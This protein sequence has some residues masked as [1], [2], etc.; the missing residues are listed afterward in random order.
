MKTVNLISF[1]F[2]LTSFHGAM[3]AT[4]NG[5][6]KNQGETLNFELSGQKNWDYDLK[7][8]KEKNQTKVQLL[9]N[10][11]TEDS[12]SKIKNVDNPYVESIIVQ[13]HVAD[14]KWLIEFVLKNDNVDT[15]DYLT[16][17]PSKL[18]VDFYVNENAQDDLIA[19]PDA[20]VKKAKLDTKAA[21]KL[22]A[23]KLPSKKS[24]SEFD[25][26]PEMAERK[27]AQAD[28]LTVDQAGGIETSSLLKGRLNDGADAFLERF[29]IKDIEINEK[30][31]LKSDNNYYLRFPMLE[32]PFSFWDKMKANPPVYQFEPAKTEEN[33]QVRLIKTLFDKK[34]FQVFAKTAEWFE[35]KY[36]KS[37]YLESIA[38]M[39]S[40]A[41]LEQWKQ[42][43][44]DKAFDEAKQSY[45]QNM[46]KYPT[47]AL[48]ERTSLMLGMLDLDKPDYMAAIRR[49]NT[50]AENPNFKDRLSADYAKMGQ[51]FAFSKIKRLEDAV[52]ILNKLESESKNPQ[53]QAEAAFRRGDFYFEDKKFTDAIL[54]YKLALKKY[55]ASE[56]QFPNATFNQ[57]E[58][59]FWLK[60]YK[61]AHQS[62]LDFVA[63]F[64]MHPHA[65]YAMT[66]V[67]ELLDILG[68]D[69]SKAVGAYLETFFR[70]GDNPKTIVARLH[71]LSTR[72]KSMKDEELKQ[73]SAKMDELAKKSDLPNVDQFKTV[74]IADGYSK[75]G[76]HQK[77]IDILANFY[78][79]NP[80][81]PDSK[82]VT[83]RIMNNIYDQIRS[84]SDAGKFKD[85]LQTVQ[86]YS[87]T[88][89][90]HN[91][92]IDT[93]YFVGLA[94]ESAGDYE[95]AL[96][97]FQKTQK[98]MLAIKGTDKEKWVSVTENLPS[99]DNLNLHIA[100]VNFQ[101]KNF[102]LAYQ[103]LEKIKTP[104]L[105]TEA[106]QIKRIQMASDLYEQKGDSDTAMRYLSE[107]VRVWN[108]KPELAIGAILRLAEMQN[109]KGLTADAQ[110]S[111]E[112]ILDIAEAN[113][114]ANV[115][116]V[117][118][119]ANFSANLYQKENKLD[120]A[121][122]RYT[123]ILNK[124]DADRN[125]PEERYKLG[126]IYF[127]KGEVKKA[128]T[129]WAQLKGEGSQFWAKLSADKLKNSQW[130]D[131][132]KK[133][134]K[135]IPAMSKIEEQ[136]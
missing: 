7:R 37:D 10:S 109:R 62:G 103:Q 94:Y 61:E 11:L 84:Y 77:S 72:M 87:D 88:W 1:L 128:E 73:T 130:K 132:Y 31:I 65:P 26:T 82:Q 16:D 80:T 91:D 41:L 134:L 136:K 125:L 116:D 133:Y 83:R 75:R 52:N 79:Q 67:G 101:M 96:D 54:N 66:R 127:K 76:D 4:I 25:E 58:S 8:V 120:D 115:R 69:Q 35:N 68:A 12:V 107:L 56:A 36:P 74:M 34:R 90:S 126:D 23:K 78:Q 117:I 40:D 3:A 28:Y 48:A 71:L 39:R 59:N 118:R 30:A 89:L 17:Q 64:N 14:G 29:V 112:K 27:P 50:H 18:I 111:L 110:K 85:V 15:F 105:L 55:P 93:D 21:A 100:D 114:K 121:A 44:T 33:K 45:V 92:R 97:K 99:E 63:K 81:R 135:R 38:F 47:S 57:M 122:K 98:S 20:K 51:A 42:N 108:G 46:Q 6:V 104:Y 22:V 2:V 131:D 32:P 19:K 70:Y 24:T 119:A 13:K 129:T 95:V 49:F 124:Y 60:K 106:D 123:F 5:L 113:P 102:Q 86:K 9:V 53:I 43:K